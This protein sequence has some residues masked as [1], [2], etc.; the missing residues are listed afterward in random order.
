MVMSKHSKDYNVDRL[1]WR[2]LPGYLWPIS[3]GFFPSISHSAC[4]TPCINHGVVRLF[5]GIVPRLFWSW[6]A[7]LYHKIFDISWHI[8]LIPSFMI[9]KSHYFRRPNC[10]VNW[11]PLPFWFPTNFEAGAAGGAASGAALGLTSGAVAGAALAT[12]NPDVGV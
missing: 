2:S 1:A 9:F 11:L 7:L 8:W 12:A 3:G 5:F 4:L 10:T 6:L